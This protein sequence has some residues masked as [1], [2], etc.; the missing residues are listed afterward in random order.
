MFSEIEE[1]VRHVLNSHLFAVEDL[2]NE[3]GTL[4]REVFIYANEEDKKMGNSLMGYSFYPDV[5]TFYLYLPVTKNTVEYPFKL[6]TEKERNE[7]LEE[8]I[9][10]IKSLADRKLMI[11][12]FF[13]GPIRIARE[14]CI[15]G[16]EKPFFQ[17]GFRW[18]KFLPKKSYHC[19]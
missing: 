2:P 14:H 16:R 5:E 18:Y 15:E 11:R 12:Q 17:N 9:L 19:A 10:L 4:S 6:F 13:L 8:V 7:F 3:D 1:C